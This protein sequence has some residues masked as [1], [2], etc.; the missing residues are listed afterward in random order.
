M[1]PESNSLTDKWTDKLADQLVDRLVE[2]LATRGWWVCETF[3]E[4]SL[5]S[6]L[7][8]D[9]THNE[10]VQLQPA[11]IGRGAIR[12]QNTDIRRDRTQWLGSTVPVQAAY[13]Q[14]M[15]ALRTR[16]NRELFLGLQEFEAHYAEFAAGGFY[17]THLDALKGSKNRIVSS[18]LY[19]NPGWE[20]GL[21]GELVLYSEQGEELACIP[22]KANSAVF[23][24]SEEF[25]HQ[26]L[27]SL[28]PRYSIA[29]W[30]RVRA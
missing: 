27:P 22:P 25:P 21:G 5:L 11:S 1:Q 8:A 29:G 28:R 14:I 18:V 7:L 9:V 15:D 30:Y 3:V 10:Q 20:P 13:L 2:A 19:L 23:F 17:A 26:V 16:F 24:L 4:E 6:A 12:Q